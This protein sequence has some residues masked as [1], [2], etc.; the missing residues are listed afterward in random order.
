MA[1]KHKHY[2]FIKAFI[3][4]EEVEWRGTTLDSAW[5]KWQA[6][7]SVAMFAWPNTEFRLKP[8]KKKS[9]GY[10]RYLAHPQMGFE[11]A[12]VHTI[13]EGSNAALR[14]EEGISPPTLLRW[15]DTE[16]QYEEYEE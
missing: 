7:G 12:V 5:D 6:V 13:W 2:E 14:L 4:G 16:W 3:D 11:Q 10:R 15:I 9:V 8:Q 1:E